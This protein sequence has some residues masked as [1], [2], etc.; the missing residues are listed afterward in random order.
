MLMIKDL[1]LQNEARGVGSP[2]CNL[3]LI[4]IFLTLVPF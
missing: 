3:N 2:I 4:P 1:K